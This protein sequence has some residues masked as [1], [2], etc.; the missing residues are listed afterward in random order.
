[1]IEKNS[2]SQNSL[3]NQRKFLYL[4][5]KF[6]SNKPP[7]PPFPS[8]LPSNMAENLY[9]N[10]QSTFTVNMRNN[11]NNCR[12]SQQIRTTTKRLSC[13]ELED[14]KEK[15]VDFIKLDQSFNQS[16]CSNSST[17]SSSA[18]PSPKITSIN[19][20]LPPPP[21]DLL[22]PKNPHT[23]RI[24][25]LSNTTDSN[26]PEPPA[27]TVSIRNSAI[28]SIPAQINRP[29]DHDDS[30]SI[31]S[32]S[33]YSTCRLNP[34]PNH[35]S[36][37]N[38]RSVFSIYEEENETCSTS[39]CVSSASNNSMTQNNLS[40]HVGSKLERLTDL[41]IKKIESMYR[42]IGSLV[43]VSAC[44]CD[45]LTTNSEQ[46]ADLLNNCWKLEI[47]CL[48]PVWLFDTGFNLKRGKRLQLLF[49][50]R[51]TAF[52]LIRKPIQ[53]E[54]LNQ[55]RNPNN[56]KRLTFTTQNPDDLK[57]I[58]LQN[59]NYNC[60]MRND[61]K[62]MVCLLQF[63]DYL[64]CHEFFRFFKDI[65]DSPRNF[66]LFTPE[67]N[68][69]NKRNSNNLSKSTLSINKSTTVQLRNEK[70]SS[71]NNSKRYSEYIPYNSSIN[72]DHS[73]GDNNM[74][75]IKSSMTVQN[76]SQLSDRNIS[77][78]NQAK[79][80]PNVRIITKTCISSPCAF[81]HVNSLNNLNAEEHFKVLLATN[82]KNN[83]K[84]LMSCNSNSCNS[85]LNVVR[86]RKKKL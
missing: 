36:V 17:S 60:L 31:K 65:V 50:N 77:S 29:P 84:N 26:K 75:S 81:Q 10:T 18:A 16:S 35:A 25:I 11:N 79:C 68:D 69:L 15:F 12:T 72:F 34:N 56:D 3:N 8:T 78:K 63:A 83:V 42:S 4:D 13:E 19:E 40:S 33:I 2:T 67:Y 71:K 58:S 49:V 24:S 76:L 30:L 22:L 38:S 52:P 62:Q 20:E 82:D 7:Q 85:M 61:D 27:R 37:R 1:M 66:D 28:Y 14:L 48:V 39:S 9:H 53:I 70:K 55:F 64:S 6:S 41:E 45:L 23:N 44:T 32:G 74:K 73:S 57:P 5:K 47:A 46:I 54:H 21:P 59:Q 80:L 51:R 43:Y 86:L